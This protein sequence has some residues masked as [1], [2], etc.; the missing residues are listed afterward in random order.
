MTLVKRKTDIP[1]FESVYSQSIYVVRSY[2]LLVSQ[3]TISQEQIPKKKTDEF[4]RNAFK[5][6]GIE[7]IYI[8]KSNYAHRGKSESLGFAFISFQATVDLSEIIR[9][10]PVIPLV[11]ENLE[12]IIS[13]PPER[14][15]RVMAM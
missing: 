7:N 12:L 4:L 2:L 1:D 15:M 5:D 6:L 14:L 3:V 9:A 8:P 13:S 11:K 10:Y